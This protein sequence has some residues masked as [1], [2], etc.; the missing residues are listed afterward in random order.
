MKAGES[1]TKKERCGG[2]QRRR[3]DNVSIDRNTGKQNNVHMERAVSS[4]SLQKNPA[5]LG[6]Q[7]GSLLPGQSCNMSTPHQL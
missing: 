6:C 5:R 4:D 7:T 1:V 3:Y 2:S